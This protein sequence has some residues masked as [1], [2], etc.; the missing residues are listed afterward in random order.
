MSN[1]A[2]VNDQD[3]VVNVIVIEQEIIDSGLFGD[4][5]TFVQTSYNTHGGVHY[6]PNTGLPSQDQSK[7]L[8]KNYAGIGYFLDRA[9]DA[10]IP[11][12]DYESWLLNEETCLWEPPTP[13]PDDG[14]LY[15]WD[16]ATTSW[17]V[18]YSPDETP[19]V[20]VP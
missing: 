18:V 15:D 13:R 4:P 9:R 10:F 16:E 20:S 3:K 7:A 2:I 14:K 1:F 6:D 12:K 17:K 8:R 5:S 19:V 11:P